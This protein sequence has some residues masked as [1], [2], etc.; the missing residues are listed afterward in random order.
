TKGFRHDTA[1]IRHLGLKIGVE[2]PSAFG[3]VE[4]RWM[5]VEVDHTFG[6]TA[7]TRRS[8]FEKSDFDRR[9]SRVGCKQQISPHDARSLQSDLCRKQ[10]GPTQRFG[11]RS[12]AH[13]RYR[14]Y[15]RL[16]C[17]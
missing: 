4:V 3:E 13:W 17:S 10:L 15:D 9:G 2:G 5:S 16:R 12:D 6:H 14:L 8:D 7:R 11:R 1:N